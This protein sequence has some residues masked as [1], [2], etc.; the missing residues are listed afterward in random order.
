MFNEKHIMKRKLISTEYDEE[1]D[2]EEK[3]AIYVV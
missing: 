2:G 3:L 1:Y